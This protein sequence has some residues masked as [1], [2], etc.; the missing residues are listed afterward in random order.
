MRLPRDAWQLSCLR[1][2][3]ARSR[4]CSSFRP[5]ESSFA[6]ST[7][8][9]EGGTLNCAPSADAVAGNGAKRPLCRRRRAKVGMG[10]RSAS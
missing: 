3:A 8:A 9:G 4:M 2:I 10:G 7:L 6:P 5:R 1:P